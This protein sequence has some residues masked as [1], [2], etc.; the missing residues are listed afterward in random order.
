MLVSSVF[1]AEQIDTLADLPAAL[2]LVPAG[3]PSPAQDYFSGDLDLNDLLIPHRV[4]TYIVR[5]SGHSM[6][7]AGIFD[8]DYLV[9]DRAAPVED[10]RIVIAVL[11]GELTVKRLRITGAHVQLCAENPNYPAIIVPELSSLEI[12]GTVQWVLHRARRG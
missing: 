8:A 2:E 5:T 3:F 4:S 10:G 11:D 1:P 7:G 12:W 6:V 9:V